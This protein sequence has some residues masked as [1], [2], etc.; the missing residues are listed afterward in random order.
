M[1]DRT[2]PPVDLTLFYFPRAC[3]LAVHIALEESGLPYDRRIVDL[4]TGENRDNEYLALNP[5]GAVP[6]LACGENTLTETQAILTYIGDSLPAGKLLPD[7]GD[8]ARYKAHEWMNFLS[9]SVHTYIRSIF[10]SA[11]Y[12]GE[13]ESVIAAVRDQGE[14][15]L[16][17]AVATVEKRLRTS[18]GKWALGDSFSVVD[19]YL[20]VMY[21]W[22]TDERIASVP[23]RPLWEALAQRVWLRPAVRN[24]VRVERRDRNYAIPWES[25]AS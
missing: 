4:R 19:C 9:S 13:D 2:S 24:V 8:M 5:N 17:K 16:A 1:T 15:N 22:T 21:L 6:A 25:G 11:V 18:S 23:V 7:R 14:I 3:S 12:A 20:F 10:R